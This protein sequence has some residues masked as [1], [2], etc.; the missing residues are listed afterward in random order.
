MS[1]ARCTPSRRG[2][3]TSFS[4][5][6]C[7]PLSEFLNSTIVVPAKAGTHNHGLWNMGPRLRGDDSGVRIDRCRGANRD[8]ALQQLPDCH[9]RDE[10][11]HQPDADGGGLVGLA[12]RPVAI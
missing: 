9:N 7:D 12:A 6:M 3:R 5:F 4:M 10:A 8:E 11:E 2:M 1:A